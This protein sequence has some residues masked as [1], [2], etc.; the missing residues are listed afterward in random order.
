MKL[1]L[2]Q[3]TMRRVALQLGLPGGVGVALLL[4]AA[5][6]EWGA[7][8]AWHRQ[9]DQ[10]NAEARRIRQTVQ[11]QGGGVVAEV[12]PEQAVS[13]LMARLPTAAQRSGVIAG[14]LQ[15]AKAQQLTIDSLQLHQTDERVEGGPEARGTGVSRQQIDVPLKG[16]YAQIRAWLVALLQEQPALSL[17]SLQLKRADAQTDLLDARVSLSLWVSD[18]RDEAKP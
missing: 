17:D 9:I 1:A 4:L 16:R 5:W 10:A 18:A 8:P 6:G 13:A 2:N 3:K 14:L 15:A 7:L 12:T 11:Q